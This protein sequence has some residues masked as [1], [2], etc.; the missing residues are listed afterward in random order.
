MNQQPPLQAMSDLEVLFAV[1]GL[2]AQPEAWFKGGIARNE[3]GRKVSVTHPRACQFSLDGAF[4]R[5]Q[6]ITKARCGPAYEL[7]KATLIQG[8]V[9]P[10]SSFNDANGTT[11]LAVL[12]LIDKGIKKLGGNPPQEEQDE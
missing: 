8:G 2:I 6:Y 12:Q 1:R 9:I 10:L 7:L 5:V 3:D 4:Y 11:H